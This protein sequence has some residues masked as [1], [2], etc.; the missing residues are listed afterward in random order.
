MNISSGLLLIWSNVKG[1]RYPSLRDQ[2]GR[3]LEPFTSYLHSIVQ[4]SAERFDPKRAWSETQAAT[5]AVTAFCDFL[6]KRRRRLTNVDQKLLLMFRND[7]F[8]KTL[9]HPSGHGREHPAA[10]T[11]NIKLRHVYDMLAW[12]QENRRIPKRTI[13]PRNCRV[14]SALPCDVDQQNSS[15]LNYPLCYRG[16]GENARI[17]ESQYWATDEDI[18]QVEEIFREKHG[19]FAAE[20]NVL[21]L[22]LGEYEGWRVGSS[23]S[24]RTEQFSDKA[25]D[26]QKNSDAFEVCPP[27]QKIGYQFSFSMPWP[28]AHFIKNYI[29]TS[30]T[31][32]MQALGISEEQ[33]Q[34]RIFLSANEGKPLRP[35]SVSGIFSAALRELGRP[36]RAAY[37]SF[38]RYKAQKIAE[39]II[40]RRTREGRSLA[41]DDVVDEIARVLGHAT[42]EAQRAYVRATKKASLRT[43]EERQH[44][45]IVELQLLIAE[46]RAKNSA[47]IQRI[48]ELSV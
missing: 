43:V 44:D 39:E 12:C 27:D 33:A 1:L 30:R 16:I 32:H 47:L 24:L 42:R 38:R 34:Y 19:L 23:N 13:G 26:A 48:N 15:K 29:S 21:F 37:H 9:V 7:A 4:T 46:E 2:E 17:D 22:R 28:L 35:R 25:F 20:R 8:N 6:Q 41:L 31:K 5:Y 36:K 14:T 11:T 10:R 3:L 45:D 40:E 18:R